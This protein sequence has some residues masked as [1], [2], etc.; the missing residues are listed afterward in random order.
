[1]L[2]LRDVWPQLFRAEQVRFVNLLI[3]R[4]QIFSDGIDVVWREV[5]WQQLVGELAP[6]AIG[7]E[8]LE[9]DAV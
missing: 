5:G 6:D 4:V 7:G 2:H 9:V 8:L 1:M 3:E